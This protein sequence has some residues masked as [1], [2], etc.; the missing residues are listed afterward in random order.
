M[1]FDWTVDD[2]QYINNILNVASAIFTAS[3]ELNEDMGDVLNLGGSVNSS[4]KV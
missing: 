1:D 4:G 3:V 2:P